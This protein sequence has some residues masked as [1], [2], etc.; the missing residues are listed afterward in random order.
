MAGGAPMKAIN[1]FV[2]TPKNVFGGGVKSARMAIAI[3][4]PK[5]IYQQVGTL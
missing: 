3:D 2:K 1:V 5:E 4:N